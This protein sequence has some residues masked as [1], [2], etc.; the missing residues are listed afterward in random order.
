MV[1]NEEQQGTKNNEEGSTTICRFDNNEEQS[2]A[3][4]NVKEQNQGD[5]VTRKIPL[6]ARKDEVIDSKFSFFTNT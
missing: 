1:Q 2:N 3:E 4:K 5:V 6:L